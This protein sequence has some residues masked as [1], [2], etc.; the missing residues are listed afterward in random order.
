ML[1]VTTALCALGALTLSPVAAQA[2][3]AAETPVAQPVYEQIDYNIENDRE[4][5]LLLDLSNGERVAIRLMPS[6]APNHVERVKTLARE[7]FYNGV[8]FHRVIDGF[9]AQTGD[10]TGTGTGKSDLPNLPAEFT[11]TPYKAGSLG[12]ARKR[13]VYHAAAAPCVR[14]D[15]L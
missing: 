1:K 3:D 7:G 2:Q 12:M 6:W 15:H 11:P 13:R 5:I 8:I 9:M 10:P 14:P 4:N